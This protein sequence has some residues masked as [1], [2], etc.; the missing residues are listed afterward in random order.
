[1]HYQGVHG[2]MF[3]LSPGETVPERISG[4]AKAVPFQVQNDGY[5]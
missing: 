1:M 3:R 4:T 5:E 2:E